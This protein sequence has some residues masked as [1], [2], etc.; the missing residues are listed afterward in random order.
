MQFFG[1]L[2]FLPVALLKPV[3]IALTMNALKK[4]PP[5]SRTMPLGAAI[6]PRRR[7]SVRAKRQR[8]HQ[9]QEH[10]DEQHDD[11]DSTKQDQRSGGE[12]LVEHA[13]HCG[14][15][16]SITAGVMGNELRIDVPTGQISPLRQQTIHRARMGE[17]R[18]ASFVNLVA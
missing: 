15:S 2:H 18:S 7:D 10:E 12:F 17:G 14:G 4:L 5:W 6:F 8:P 1:R 13:V 11:D 16:C 9:L 3:H